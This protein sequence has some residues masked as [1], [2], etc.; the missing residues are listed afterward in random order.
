MSLQDLQ[1]IDWGGIF[2]VA[3]VLVAGSLGYANID[4]RLTELERHKADSETVAVM[5]ADIRY[6]RK[7]V[8]EVKEELKQKADK[9]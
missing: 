8:D 1:Q 3:G 6:I 2:K 4:S 7:S 9:P 5:A